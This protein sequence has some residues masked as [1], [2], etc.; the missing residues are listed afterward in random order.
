MAEEKSWF[1]SI[2]DRGGE[3]LGGVVDIAEEAGGSWLEHKL[4]PPVDEQRKA[5]QDD[6]R[7]TVGEPLPDVQ[8]PQSATIDTKTMLI[9]G[10]VLLVAV[11]GVAF[12]VRGK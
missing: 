9:A 3:L 8:Q 12:A 7:N 4:A 2:L 10:G 5:G 6:S 1:D 11:V